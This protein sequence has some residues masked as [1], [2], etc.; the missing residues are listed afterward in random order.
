MTCGLTGCPLVHTDKDNND[1]MSIGYLQVVPDD[2]E[3]E[4]LQDI[5]DR[6]RRLSIQSSPAK[7]VEERL[8][9]ELADVADQL[10]AFAARF[11][12]DVR[13]MES[14]VTITTFPPPVPC[15]KP[16]CCRERQDSYGPPVG[17]TLGGYR[18]RI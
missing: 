16:G 4:E 9:Q 15:G 5:R 12:A 17:L 6:A 10:D 1:S 2:F 13:E 18:K 8:Y 3:R 7:T 11:E 14:S